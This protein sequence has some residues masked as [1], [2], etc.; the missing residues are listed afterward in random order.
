MLQQ[1]LTISRNTFLESIRQPIFVVLLIVFGLALF[2]NPSLSANTLDDD[3][4]LMVA[5]GMSTLFLAGLFMAAFTATGVLASEI[6][7]KTVL[8]VVSKPVSR[9]LFV[10]GKYFGV[11]GALGLAFWILGCLFILTVR[12]R[13][14]QTASDEFDGPVIVFGLLCWLL[15]LTWAGW[16]NYFHRWV[17]S[18]TFV[19][20][21]AGLSTLAVLLVLMI[22]KHWQFQSI[23]AEFARTENAALPG[24][25]ML[26]VMV[27]LFEAI[28][29][30]TAVAIAA[31]T[32]LGQI[33]TLVICT[34][35]FVLG[36]TSEILLAPVVQQ[37]TWSQAQGLG[38][39]SAWGLPRI[40]Y[41]GVPNFQFL[42]LSEALQRGI[43]IPLSHVLTVSLYALLVITAVL[44]LAVILFQEREVS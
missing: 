18:S 6:E 22:D 20:S 15:A 10:L 3:N 2:L 1:I 43:P 42:W 36:L 17:F 27:L 34:G 5:M 19:W 29:M 41:W 8:T 33:M 38:G 23:T 7:N 4:K 13:V 24:G 44:S 16:G 26:V 35:V 14:M 9:P 39:W 40:L 11:A 25:E 30:L 28:L 37:T 32:R 31:S 21:L 12:H